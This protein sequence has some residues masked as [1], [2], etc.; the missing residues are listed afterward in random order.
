MSRCLDPE[1]CVGEPPACHLQGA[2]RDW[3]TPPQSRAKKSTTKEM[4]SRTKFTKQTGKPCN[5]SVSEV[6]LVRRE[7]LFWRR[8][9][10]TAAYGEM[11]CVCACA[12][13]WITCA[14]ALNMIGC[15]PL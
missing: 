7:E 3:S 8:D 13:V 9:I 4:E 14:C 5:A 6:M 11:M 10:I 1:R 2:D 15:Q 12:S